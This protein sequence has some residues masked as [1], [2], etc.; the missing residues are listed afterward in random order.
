MHKLFKW[1]L[2]NNYDYTLQACGGSYFYNAPGLHIDAASV[3]ISGP[4]I[5]DVRNKQRRLESYVNRY[6]Y[7]ILHDNRLACDCYGVY[8]KTLLIISNNGAAALEKYNLFHSSASADCELLIH[9]YHIEGIY[10][11]H[12]EQLEQELRGIM[13]YYGSLYNQALIVPVNDIKTA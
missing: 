5:S 8:H 9:K 1:L 13:D 7:T 10:K 6:N 12:H 3:E 11:T 2:K 4:D